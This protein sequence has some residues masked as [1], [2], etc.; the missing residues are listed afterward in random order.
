MNG[1]KGTCILHLHCSSVSKYFVVVTRGRQNAKICGNT[2]VRPT[3]RTYFFA[4]VL[5]DE[6]IYTM[7]CTLHSFEKPLP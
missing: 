2:L 6:V 3:E 4:V 7:C 1:R 5:T